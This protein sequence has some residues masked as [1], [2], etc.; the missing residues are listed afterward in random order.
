MKASRSVFNGHARVLVQ[1]GWNAEEM[2][3]TA[4]AAGGGGS[5]VPVV[6]SPATLTVLVKQEVVKEGQVLSNGWEEREVTPAAT[7]VGM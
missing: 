4:T 3:L 1:A 7:G 5:S 6:L 2:V